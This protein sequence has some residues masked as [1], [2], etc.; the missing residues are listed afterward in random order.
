MFPVSDSLMQTDRERV[1]TLCGK[2][3]IPAPLTVP[4]AHVA[5]RFGL[6]GWTD[7]DVPIYR[8]MLDDPELWRF[9]PE[10]YPGAITEDLARSFIAVSR[11]A[12]HHK[13]RAVT[14][15]GEIIGQVRM[16]WNTERTPPQTGEISYW[17]GRAH[18]G[19]GSAAPMIALFTW[20]C[21]STYPALS[22]ITARVH[23]DNMR[24]AKVLQR[25]G[26]AESGT[27]GDW[28]IFARDRAAGVDWTCLP[29]GDAL[30]T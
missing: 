11:E 12:S 20:R 23:C 15:Q 18:W 25:L 22:C 16:H 1:E 10:D 13:V 24:S 17:L 9:M 2:Q 4:P 28:I 7:A 30:S 6:R 19:Q 5:A 8:A 3:I 26:W 27:Q 14:C 29:Q 21:L